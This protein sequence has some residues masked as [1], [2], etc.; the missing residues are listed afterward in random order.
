MVISCA[1]V[2]R[3]KDGT[4]TAAMLLPRNARRVMGMAALVMGVI[5]TLA[6]DAIS[7]QRCDT[8]SQRS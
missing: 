7:L 2:G 8:F 1:L 3:D 5:S 6:F 4:A